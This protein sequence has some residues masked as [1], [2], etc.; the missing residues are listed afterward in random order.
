MTRCQ[1]TLKAQKVNLVI[2]QK[3]KQTHKIQKGCTL[4][5]FILTANCGGL[6]PCKHIPPSLK[7]N[8]ITR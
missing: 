1:R 7:Q 4:N 6:P 3:K 5:Y 8:S 2:S